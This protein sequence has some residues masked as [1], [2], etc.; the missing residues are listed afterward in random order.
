MKILVV[1]LGVIG[2]GYGWALTDAQHDVT[3]LLRPGRAE[4]VDRVYLDILDMRPGRP[5]WRKGIYRP[6]VTEAVSPDDRFD[7][8]MVPVKHYE[9]AGTLGEL[10]A[11]LP[12]GHFLLMSANW[13][14]L[15]E[16]DAVLPRSQYLWAYPASTGGHED[17]LLVFNV[18]PQYRTGPIDG[19]VPSW[20]RQ[21]H[22][23]FQ[24]MDMRPDRKADMREWLW[25]NFAQAAG[26]I[27]SVLYA[28]G[29]R[30]FYEDEA[31]LRD[32]LVPA[33]REC[34][35]VL[36]ARGVDPAE[37][38]EVA[39]FLESPPEQIAAATKAT[40]TTPWV[41]RTLSTGHFV[42]NAAEMRRFYF[43]VLRTGEALGVP[44]PVMQSFR[45]K[46]LAGAE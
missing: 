41:Q 10:K 44:M 38:P 37:W 32:R 27:G 11:A 5:R 39:P 24:A 31:G 6:K 1:G 40:A 15:D 17:D 26:T 18:S 28:G 45:E 30:Q 9:L 2:T 12:D 19:E 25:L 33:V 36:A 16:I 46:V 13:D 8:V 20:A 21:V 34:L 22:D 7:L 14:G 43:D 42:E 35:A 29:L 23:L 3:H 4:G